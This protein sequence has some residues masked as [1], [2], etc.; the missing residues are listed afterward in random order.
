MAGMD[1]VDIGG[2]ASKGRPQVPSPTS[3]VHDESGFQVVSK[4]VAV[5]VEEIPERVQRAAS[6]GATIAYPKD[7]PANNEDIEMDGSGRLKPEKG[8]VL[9]TPP[10]ILGGVENG[11]VSDQKNVL[12]YVEK[13]AV[14]LGELDAAEKEDTFVPTPEQLMVMRQQDTTLAKTAKGEPLI[15]VEFHLEQGAVV[16]YYNKVE[17]QGRW[18]I[19]IVDNAAPA[20]QRFVPRPTKT[21][22]IPTVLDI[23]VTGADRVPTPASVVPLGIQFTV[24]GYDFM[25][26]LV[27]E[28]D[29]GDGEA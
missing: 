13:M 20:K 28:I 21:G 6:N 24:D 27:Q 17:Q 5:E 12:D 19:F 1:N 8:Q 4:P 23:V 10:P 7:H 11:F 18:L 2:A 9:T 14:E 15:E 22:E 25:V 16:G 29:D 26:M 3:V